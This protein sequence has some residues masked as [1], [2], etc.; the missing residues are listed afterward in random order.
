MAESHVVSG[1]VAKRSELSDLL[2]RHQEA[3]RQL[4]V[5]ITGLDGTIKLFDPDYDLRTIKSKAPKPVNPW[6][7]RGDVGRMLLDVL[8][9]SDAPLSTRQIGDALV[10]TRGIVVAEAQELH[11]IMKLVLAAAKRL[12]RK[13]I[14][15]MVGRI[16]G[17]GGGGSGTMLWQIA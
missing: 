3:I 15:K 12:E 10:A 4:S 13:G 2:V 7:P 6:F 16:A 5:S 8:R 1:L 11:D 14:I 9:K 17:Y